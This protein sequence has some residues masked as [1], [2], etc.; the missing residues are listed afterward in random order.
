MLAAVES[1]K[2]ADKAELAETFRSDD[3]AWKAFM[4]QLYDWEQRKN[5]S[6]GKK[7]PSSKPA[8]VAHIE[9]MKS[10]VTAKRAEF[11]E[12][13][14]FLGSIWTPAI[15]QKEKGARPSRKALRTFAINCQKIRGVLMATSE[16]TPVGCIEFYSISQAGA[17]LCGEVATSDNNTGEELTSAWESEQKRQRITSA[18]RATA[19]G[20]AEDPHLLLKFS[21]EPT[22]D[23]SD[24]DDDACFSAIWGPRLAQRGSKKRDCEESGGNG[25]GST[26]SG[27]GTSH[28]GVKRARTPQSKQA[29]GAITSE[30]S[31]HTAFKAQKVPSSKGVLDSSEQVCLSCE[32]TRTSLTTGAPCFVSWDGAVFPRISMGCALQV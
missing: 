31:P 14:R 28:D 27:E 18:R 1:Y 13:R 16:G 7:G 24:A 17:E 20:E 21:A 9:Q 30:S 32:Q 25:D 6:L 5:D 12:F 4:E 19:E 22:H 23:D 15:Y 29:K 8:G 3:K 10:G 2:D 11:H 26:G